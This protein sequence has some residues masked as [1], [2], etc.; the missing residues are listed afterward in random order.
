MIE[1]RLIQHALALARFRNFARAAEALHLTQ[2][3]LSRSIATLERSL[4]VQLFDRDKKGIRPT[5]FGELLLARG[6]ALVGGEADLRREIQLLAGLEAGELAIGAGPYPAEISV[7]TAVI[8]LLRAHARLKVHVMSGE[9]DDIARKVLTG[10]LDVGAVDPMDLVEAPR[11]VVE[12]LAAHDLYLACRPG[13][14]LAGAPDLTLAQILQFPLA[15]TM[16][17][18]PAA[19]AAAGYD[20]AG[21]RDPRTG[22]IAPAVHV[23]SL[24]LARQIARDS[25][26][27]FPATLSMLAEDIAAGRLVTLAFR[28]PVMRTTY[29]LVTLRDRSLSPAASAFIRHLRDVEAEIA[30]SEARAAESTRR[31]TSSAANRVRVCG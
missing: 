21:T 15:T 12:R 29:C 25:D 1:F 17:G 4:G 10:E 14:P 18:G 30:R 31:R 16:F 28:I 3:S 13:H 6:A 20:L 8:R 23:N 11:L 19:E 27:L 2:P 24:A 9:P 7:S 22:N 5:V 26:A